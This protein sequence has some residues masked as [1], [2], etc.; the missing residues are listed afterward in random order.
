VLAAA[1][2]LLPPRFLLGQA[3]LM[4]GNSTEAL[5]IANALKVEY[6]RQSGGYV[7]EGDVNV[8][9]RR[10][11]A[12]ADAF[13][14]AFEHEATWSV[15]TRLLGA[16]QLA[17]RRADA[18]RE[19]E[20]WVAANPQHLAGTLT[21]AGLLQAAGRAEDALR[22]YENLLELDAENL[23]AL[24]NAAWLAHE[25]SRPVALSYAER[26]YGLASDNPAVLDT[27][28]WILLGQNREAEAVEHLSRAAELAPQVS[29]IRYHFASALAEVGQSA[30][31][32]A[33]L[34]PL[35]QPGVQFEQREEAERLL[36]SL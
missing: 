33:V 24:N 18:L 10:Y 13:S 22:V 14:A 2:Q 31:A 1:P 16:L 26:A 3:E 4:L 28:G 6:P 21:L 29:E 12:A 23:V 7:L 15:M 36:E 35:L 32:R 19:N 20:R 11:A 9:A 30:E 34:A 27:L 17:G 8:A 5:T 25:L